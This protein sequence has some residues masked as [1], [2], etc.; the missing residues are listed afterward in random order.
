MSLLLHQIKTV[1]ITHWIE[2]RILNCG[3]SHEAD[4]DVAPAMKLTLIVDPI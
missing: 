3:S 1:S 4:T 2:W